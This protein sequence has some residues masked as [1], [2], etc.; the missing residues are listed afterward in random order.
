MERGTNN[1]EIQKK[2][3]YNAHQIFFIQRWLELLNGNTHNKYSVRFLNS[4]QALKEVIYVCEGMLGEEIKSNDFH[5]KLVFEEARSIISADELLKEEAN[6]H[7]KIVERSLQSSPKSSQKSKLYSIVFQLTYVI[8]H[9]ET[10]Y[11][12]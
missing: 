6:S 2:G 7:H 11:L 9:L 4:H 8:R 1:T 10:N 5:L 3:N 12:R